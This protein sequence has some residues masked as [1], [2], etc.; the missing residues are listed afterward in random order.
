MFEIIQAIR[1]EWC[2][3]DPARIIYNPH[4]FFWMD[5]ATGR[6]L[7]EAGFDVIRMIEADSSFRGVPLLNNRST[8]HYPARAG[9]VLRLHTKVSRFGRTSFDVD[10]RFFLGPQP[11]A[12]GT[13]VRVWTRS[14][15][16]DPKRLKSSPLPD[17]VRA[18]LSTP[19]TRDL[20]PVPAGR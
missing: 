7:E 19:A 11:V 5:I 14:H 8:F 9:D 6:L 16:E 2:H 13:E 1:V 18:A 10:H 17:E 12:E 20:S 15:P 4:Y 3:C